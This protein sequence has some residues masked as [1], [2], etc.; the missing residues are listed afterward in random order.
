MGMIAISLALIY[1]SVGSYLSLFRCERSEQSV[2]GEWMKL[3]LADRTEAILRNDRR[4]LRT[5]TQSPEVLLLLALVPNT[6]L[7]VDFMDAYL[8][9]IAEEAGLQYVRLIADGLH[10]VPKHYINRTAVVVADLTD[11]SEAV[12]TLLYQTFGG[13]RRILLTARNPK[14]VPVDLADLTTLCYDLENG[15]FESLL[16]ELRHHTLRRCALPRI[17]THQ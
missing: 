16:E 7:I 4:Q 5:V 6:G 14:E 9:E 13:S 10:E 1:D 3:R 12:V 8:S 11:R 15:L 17:Q 2:S